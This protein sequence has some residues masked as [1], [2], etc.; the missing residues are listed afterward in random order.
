MS[1]VEQNRQIAEH[2][3]ELEQGILHSDDRRYWQT[4]TC[5]RAPI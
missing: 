1:Q 2:N 3:A 4:A 5:G